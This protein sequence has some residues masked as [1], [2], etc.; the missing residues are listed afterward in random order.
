MGREIDARTIQLKIM[1]YAVQSLYHARACI[2]IG[3]GIGV[4]VAESVLFYTDSDVHVPLTAR[5]SDAYLQQHEHFFLIQH[6]CVPPA[7]GIIRPRKWHRQ[8][9]EIETNLLASVILR[10]L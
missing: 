6:S 4:V 7:T 2:G 9:Q 5:M 8:L 1:M 3:I 10:S